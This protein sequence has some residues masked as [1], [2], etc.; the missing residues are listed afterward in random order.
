MTVR[1]AVTG[2]LTAVA[3]LAGA[4]LGVPAPA[5]RAD[6]TPAPVD[7][8]PVVMGEFPL[9]AYAAEAAEAPPEL[10]EALR[11]DLGITPEQFFAQ[12]D[13]AAT[14]GG[15][16]DALEAAGTVVLGSRL[17]GTEL[18]VSVPSDADA[19][20]VEEAGAVAEVS[21]QP[22]TP[23]A[24]ARQT[25]DLPDAELLRDLVGGQGYYDHKGLYDYFCSVGFNGID[26]TSG[27][28]QFL[29]AGHCVTPGAEYGG[30]VFSLEQQA[31]GQVPPV[32]GT[33][34]GS[35]LPASLRFGDFYDTAL[36][37]TAPAWT[38]LPAVGSWGGN[39]GPA[40][41]GEGVTVRDYTRAVVNQSICKSG[42][43]TGW[44]CGT[45][46]AVDVESTIGST[47]VNAFLSNVCALSGDSGGAVVSGSYAVGVISFGDYKTGCGE[48][49]RTTGSFPIDSK[50]FQSAL[51]V[52]TSWEPLVEVPVPTS[53]TLLGGVPL[54]RGEAATGTVPGGGL[55]NTVHLSVD[56]GPEKLVPVGA[57][58]RWSIPD[59]A[60]LTPGSHGVSLYT[61]YGAG[62][63]RSPAVTGTVLVADRP[64]VDRLDGAT[65][66]DVAVAVADEAFPG[67]A[68]VVYVATGTNYPDALSAGPAAVAKGGP[69]LPVL[70]DTV[71][72]VVAAKIA[73]L[74][75]ARI[76]IVGGTDSV[77]DSVRAAL[78][79][80]VP[81]A[82]VD[83]LAGAD[84]YEASRSVV[85]DAFSVEPHAYVATGGGFADALSAGGAAGSKGEP[86]VL[87]NGPAAAADAPTLELFQ[88]LKSGSLTVAGGRFSVSEGVLDSLSAGV[89]AT[90]TRVSGDD[91]YSTSVAL[92]ADA[93]DQADTVYLA[94][95]LNFPDALAGGVLAGLRDAPLYV[96]PGTC[97]P[98]GVLAG[99][100][101]LGATD[102]VLLG[103]GT[104]LTPAVEQL[105]PC[106]F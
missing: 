31:P 61:S 47:E 84:R 103:G 60:G 66:F 29:T 46:S 9:Q 72:E 19:D 8:G 13:A 50:F 36:Y 88:T 57:D 39:Q 1:T 15:V 89:P 83:R 98:R 100:A 26:T 22:G 17:E 41:A 38:P 40:D 20:A 67:T 71:P 6:E 16:V 80:L 34:L 25:A 10:V 24:P 42:R 11:R 102:V 51:D 35:P 86:V 63:Q 81:D 69:L 54:Y 68:P 79:Q 52:Q 56:G 18:V 59:A 33:H 53:D 87:V 27:A 4:L 12:A 99:I 93:F 75:P 65:R 2:S 48:A 28:A 55:R 3:L 74:K 106:S 91:R 7:P 62:I 43:K 94:T 73:A 76:V 21:E 105:A 23:G 85:A 5:A 90:V 97:V 14:A 45:V 44:T 104:A 77:R 95:G 58:G 37:A 96:V 32:A 49:G 78:Q 101:E 92:N 70:P 64:A 82:R 30:R